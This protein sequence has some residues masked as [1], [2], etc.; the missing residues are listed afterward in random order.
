[1]NIPSISF[2]WLC[3]GLGIYYQKWNDIIPNMETLTIQFL[4]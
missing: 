1:M 2:S 4:F 3:F